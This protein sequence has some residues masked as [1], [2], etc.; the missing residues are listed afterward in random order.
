MGGTSP[1]G[2]RKPLTAGGRTLQYYS[3]YALAGAGYR[4]IDRLP[5]SLTILL[6]SLLRQASL[7]DV[8]HHALDHGR[9]KPG[10]RVA[11]IRFLP[12]L[13][14]QA[15]N[16]GRPVLLVADHGRYLDL[17]GRLEELPTGRLLATAKGRFFPVTPS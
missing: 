5:Y 7:G 3:L 12:E 16:Y 10:W 1:F 11:D 15:R 14:A 2:T 4:E 8:E 17:E 9:E 13:L 6:E